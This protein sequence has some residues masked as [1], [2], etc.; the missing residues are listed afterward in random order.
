MKSYDQTRAEPMLIR[1]AKAVAAY[2]QAETLTLDEGDLLAGRVRRKIPGHPGI[3]EGYQWVYAAAYPDIVQNPAVLKDAPVPSEFVQFLE[4]WARRHVPAGAKV[5][6]LRP[7]ETS[8]AM[9][10]CAF[11]ASGLDMVHRL[12]RFQM[13]LEKG[14]E[15]LRAEAVAR[16]RALDGTKCEDIKKRVFYQALIITYDAMIAYSHRW[17]EKLA[18]LAQAEG[19]AERRRELD[20]MAAHCRQAPAKPPRTFWE[21]LQSV[22]LS[23]CVNQ[24]ETSG[25]A[26]S[27]GRLD[28]YLYPYYKADLEA[29]RLTY[30]R[31]LEVVQCLFLKCYR[32]FDFHHTMLG[33]LTPD[34]A[35]GTNDLSYLCLDAVARLRTPRDIA[36]RIHRNTPPEFLRKAA[37]LSRLGLGRPD[38]WN[39]EV[40]IPSLVKAGFPLADA[41]DYAAIG[42]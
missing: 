37:D 24:A 30:E 1:R 38:L 40:M 42:C 35:D 7:P 8:R 3:H 23:L 39:D 6:A 41:R 9:Q 31:A 28:Q 5:N 27:F 12:P 17:A 36:V 32:T 2:L 20:Q 34:G 19:N 21:A 22:W 11:T 25:S 33:G 15:G 4:G 13:I 18:D 29:G 10:V 26:S 16:M 14:A